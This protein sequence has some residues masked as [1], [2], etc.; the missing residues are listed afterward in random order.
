MLGTAATSKVKGG[1]YLQG[2]IFRVAGTF[3]VRV[4]ELQILVIASLA[5]ENKMRV[6]KINTVYT[7]V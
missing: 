5:D 7:Q 1:P 4:L 6:G 2:N 3:V